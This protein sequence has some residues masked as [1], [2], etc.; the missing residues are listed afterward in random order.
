M[1]HANI[2]NAYTLP[3]KFYF[4][5]NYFDEMREQI[6]NRSWN[7][8]GP[9]DDP[10]HNVKPVDLLPEFLSEPL[11]LA[12]DRAGAV[13]C[14]SNVCTHRGNLVVEEAGTVPLLRCRYHGRCFGHD[15]E[16]RSMPG[17]EDV[18]GFPTKE[19]NLHQLNMRSLGPMH[20]AQMREGKSFDDV[21]GPMLDDMAWVPY[22]KLTFRPDASRD[23]Y[24]DAHWALYCDNYLEGFH[25]PYVHP[26]LNEVLDVDEYTVELYPNSSLQIGVADDN[27]DVELLPIPVDHRLGGKRIYAM[28]WWVFPNLMFNFY[29]WGISFNCVE[30]I[31]INKTRIRFLSFAYENLPD[32]DVTS[33]HQTEIE[34]EVVVESVQ[35]GLRSSFYTRGR[36]SPKHEKAVHHFHRMLSTILNV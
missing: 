24:V 12:K 26:G 28:Y 14:L 35:K 21:F 7:F 33:I 34:D 31:S 30:P 6:F 10:S 27:E 15:G 22:G 18:E 13:R 25:V 2:N 3:A 20:F 19:D 32:P 5:Q 9:F 11:L 1:V 29:P 16:F 23:Y 36:F 4:S 8:L 17:F